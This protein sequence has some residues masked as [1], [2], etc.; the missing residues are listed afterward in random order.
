MA[1]P[2][3]LAKPELRNQ[4]FILSYPA[5]EI[6]FESAAEL[7]FAMDPQSSPKTM[8][9][10]LKDE[11]EPLAKNRLLAVQLKKHILQRSNMGDAISSLL[12]SKLSTP[13]LPEEGLFELFQTTMIKNPLLVSHMVQDLLWMREID[14]A[15]SSYLHPFLNFK[16]FHAVQTQRI[17]HALWTS[18][19]SDEADKMIALTLQSRAA[20]LF[21]V[22]AHPGAVLRHGIMLDHATGVVIG[23][24]ATI[25]HHCYILHGVT[26]GATGKSGAFDRH[27][28]IGNRV[29]IGAGAMV[30]GNIQVEDDAVLGASSVVTVPIGSG[31]TVVGI[32]RVLGSK[33]KA[34][35]SAKGHNMLTWMYQI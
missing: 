25:G 1:E 31:E 17:A 14:P 32:N 10:N 20:E 33:E 2:E 35:S 7:P 9:L 24:T 16:G 22:D 28:K 12:A 18:Q 21:G 11:A 29:K 4:E 15:T 19:S 34:E 8:F 27:P 26:L 23:E 5:F 30:L 6:D 13:D 3:L